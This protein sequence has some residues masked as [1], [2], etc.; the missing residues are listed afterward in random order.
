MSETDVT[1]AKLKLLLEEF[2]ATFK[3]RTN[4]PDKF[5]T[6]TELETLWSRLRSDTNV[7]YS[8]LIHE[9]VKNIDER[10]LNR[11]KKGSSPKKASSSETT[12]VPKKTS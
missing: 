1:I 12:D 2:E 9:L 4:D 7:L 8:D 10:D 3:A 5:L 6:M 11:K